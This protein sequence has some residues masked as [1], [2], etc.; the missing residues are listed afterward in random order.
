MDWRYPVPAAP[1][2]AAPAGPSPRSVHKMLVLTMAALGVAALMQVLVYALLIVNRT[3]LLNPVLAAGALWLSRLA[4]LAATAAVLGCAVLL[5]RWLIARRSAAFAQQQLPE[6]R[7]GWALWAGCLVPV[8]NLGWAPVYAIELAAREGRF[9]RLRK[10]IMA[11]WLLWVLSTA[12]AI[13]ATATSWAHDAQG[14]ANNTVAMTVAY[15]L[16]LVAAVA[17]GKVFAAFERRGIERPA[18]RWV[19]VGDDRAAPTTA[20]EPA[21]SAAELES[22]GREPA[23]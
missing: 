19:V 14:I 17:T 4:S 8:V 12:A 15:L 22:D 23:A 20:A 10:P 21:T 9:A 13:F 3:A 7:P 5:T 2:P 18:H 1:K 6:P 16:G 11:W